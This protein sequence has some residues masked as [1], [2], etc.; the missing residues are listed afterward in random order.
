MMMMPSQSHCLRF[1]KRSNIPSS[2]LGL[3]YKPSTCW[4]RLMLSRLTAKA[5][6]VINEEIQEFVDPTNEEML[7]IRKLMARQDA[8]NV[9]INDAREYQIELFERAK[10]Q[11]IVAVLDTGQSL[12]PYLS[13]RTF[14]LNGVQERGKL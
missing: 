11:N 1:E 7:S 14:L 6:E 8:A 5:E 3:S 12:F 9:L 13:S 4:P 10:K 2:I